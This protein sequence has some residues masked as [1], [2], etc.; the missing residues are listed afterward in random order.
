MNN[1]DCPILGNI[2]SRYVLIRKWPR[3]E[4]TIQAIRLQEYPIRDSQLEGELYSL[5][6]PR[7]FEKKKSRKLISL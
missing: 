3:W 1:K 5:I 7:P 4:C 2:V 6:I